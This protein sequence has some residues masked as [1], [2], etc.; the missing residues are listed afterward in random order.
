MTIRDDLGYDDTGR[1]ADVMMKLGAMVGM[2]NDPRSF[3]QHAAKLEGAGVEY[4]WTGEAYTSDEVS[5]MGCLAAVTER[6][7]IGS[8]I[9]PVYTR[10]P[11]LLAM[12]AVGL[13]G[14]SGGRFILGLGASGPQVIEGFRAVAYDSPLG[15]TR[16][17]LAICRSASRR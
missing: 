16:Q 15:R 2:R 5:A 17:I 12:T 10:T 11:A 4:L 13:D 7:Q 3:A 1:G 6:A 8:S 9:L 14:L